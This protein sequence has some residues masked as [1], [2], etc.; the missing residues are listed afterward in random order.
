MNEIFSLTQKDTSHK[1]LRV[2]KNEEYFFLLQFETMKHTQDVRFV[3]D[4]P[5]QMKRPS[6][7]QPVGDQTRR[8]DWGAT[9]TSIE[10]KIKVTDYL[11]SL[12]GRYQFVTIRNTLNTSYIIHVFWLQYNYRTFIDYF[13][14]RSCNSV[15]LKNVLPHTYC[16][17][18]TLKSHKTFRRHYLLFRQFSH[19]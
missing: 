8:L 1:L 15:W 9:V 10:K 7:Q 2:V 17:N 5:T 14:T 4:I 18:H 13:V 19:L 11:V 12:P 6:K 3:T 16:I